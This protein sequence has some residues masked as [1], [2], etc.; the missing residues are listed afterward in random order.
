MP[1]SEDRI[2]DGVR[3]SFNTLLEERVKDAVAKQ[4]GK[5]VSDLKEDDYKPLLQVS[6]D[7]N[8]AFYDIVIKEIISE[9]KANAEV[10]IDSKD[11]IGLDKTDVVVT[12]PPLTVSQ[13]A[14]SF[15]IQNPAP[16]PLKGNVVLK[17]ISG[18]VKKG[19]IK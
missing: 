17:V 9:I 7:A 8:M 13:G 14:G 3:G 6:V 16:I 2:L 19:N 5:N 15:V 11:K 4:L 12:I 10:V 18:R 1:I